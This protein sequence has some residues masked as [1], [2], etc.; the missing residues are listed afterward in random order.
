MH[1][2]NL[3]VDGKILMTGSV[4]LTHNGMERNKEHLYRITTKSAIEDVMVDFDRE[5][6]E[7][8]Q[9]TQ[10]MID[11][12]M[13]KWSK[14]KEPQVSRSRSLSGPRGR[15]P[16]SAVSRSLTSELE[17]V[18]EAVQEEELPVELVTNPSRRRRGRA[19]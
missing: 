14:R 17:S 4:N 10:T 2:K 6:A 12:M 18:S 16:E 5:W 13:E 3:V 11:A 15:N 7:A 19:T 8:T 9:V 1:V